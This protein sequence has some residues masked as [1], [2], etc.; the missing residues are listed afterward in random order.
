M[1]RATENCPG[2]GDTMPDGLP[3][4][5]RGCHLVVVL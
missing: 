1:R 4:P 3:Q 5:E 2:F